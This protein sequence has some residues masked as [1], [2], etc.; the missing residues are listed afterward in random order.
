MAI[1]EINYVITFLNSAKGAISA[2]PISLI[3]IS[4]KMK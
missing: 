1:S 4:T 2:I 3:A